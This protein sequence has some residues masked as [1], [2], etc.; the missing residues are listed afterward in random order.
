MKSNLR[1][2]GLVHGRISISLCRPDCS[3]SE[4]DISRRA[5][6]S[7]LLTSPVGSVFALECSVGRPGEE[8]L[9]T[10]VM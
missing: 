1:E 4:M 7:Y 3:Y 9:K 10:G 5:K 8:S 2:A 6:V